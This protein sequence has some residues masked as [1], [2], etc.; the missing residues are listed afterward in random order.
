[1]KRMGVRAGVHDYNLPVPRGIYHSLWIEL[2]PDVK[3]YYPRASQGQIE[4]RR[5]MREVGNAAFI[6]KGWEYAIAIMLDYLALD[7]GE[8]MNEVD[9]YG[10]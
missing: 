7:I 1:M 5:K 6:V 10:W 2:K 3:G 8:S 4:W 9:E